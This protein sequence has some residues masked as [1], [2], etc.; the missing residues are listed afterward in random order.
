MD[1]KTGKKFDEIINMGVTVVK[2]KGSALSEIWINNVFIAQ[3][4]YMYIN[5]YI[6]DQAAVEVLYP[7]DEAK[8][9]TQTLI[10][11][12]KNI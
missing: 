12:K 5:H 8:T 1:S 10:G 9:Y 3:G 2:H 6:E 4:D 11:D 7:E